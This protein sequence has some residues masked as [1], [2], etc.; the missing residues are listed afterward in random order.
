MSHDEH[1]EPTVTHHREIETNLD[2]P[3]LISWGAI[4]GGL[5]CIV[6]LSWLLYLLGLALGVSIA[7][8]TDGDAIGNGL[9]IGAT[10]WIIVSSLLAFFISS[11]LAARL[12]GKVDSTV[13]MLHGFVL[14]GI[15]TTTMLVLSYCGVS[16]LLQTGANMIGSTASTV[17]NIATSVASTSGDAAVAV[18]SAADT[19]LG[20]NIQ[21]RLKRRAMSVVSR[22]AAEHAS[23]VSQA[24]VREAI[25]SLDSKTL[26]SIAKDIAAGETTS[27]SEALADATK[28]SQ[29]EVN[30]IVAGISD[31]FQ[32]Q[33]GTADNKTDLGGDIINAIQRRT[34]DILADLDAEG[35]AT[36]TQQDLQQA[37]NELSPA[38]MQKVGM[39]LAN[40]DVQRAKDDLTNNTSLK[41]KQI[42]DIVDGVNAD[43]SRTV[44]QYR[45]EAAQAV[46]TAST[47]A[48]AV[49]WT[50][51][52][53]AAMSLVVSILGGMMGAETSRTL[54]LEERTALDGVTVS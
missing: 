36:V 18:S 38:T 17:S 13:G 23:G 19:R 51:F 3:P 35:G 42:N 5:V 48:Q 26:A 53:A 6:S 24:E 9:G 8:A 33:L 39:S 16:T 50:V 4:L 43:V 31:Q 25:E 15:G 30:E 32:E 10:I 52:V 12:S 44:E 14:W 34:A 28:L 7:D 46:E 27:A 41:G 29:S 1:H 47:Y 11:I 40:G 54:Y 49:L 20:E 22:T 2:R 45:A 21:A 37:M